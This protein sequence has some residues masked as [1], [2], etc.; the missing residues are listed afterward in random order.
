MPAASALAPRR[1][2]PGRRP[3]AVRR[4]VAG[5][6][7]GRSDLPGRP[8]RLRQVDPAQGAR[9]ADRARCR[10]ALPPA[11]HQ[12]RLPAAGARA[13]AGGQ[14]ARGDRSAGLPPGEPSIEQGRHRAL[15]AARAPR[16]SIPRRRVATLSGG[17]ARR[18]ALARALVG[19]PDVLLLDEPTNHLDLPTIERLEQ[20]L[21]GVS[22]RPRPGQPRPRL[23]RRAQPHDLVA[24]SR[25]ACGSWSRA[26]RPSTP[27]RRRCSPRRRRRCAG[28]RSASRR[29]PT[30]RTTASPRAASATRAGCA[31]CR[32]CARSARG[33]R[34]RS[35]R[36]S[37]S[38][39]PTRR[40]AGW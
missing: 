36:P 16:R 20:D 32:R 33:E 11:A 40:A 9:R 4:A 3:D 1:H 37:S 25:R 34:R 6:R 5:D 13:R 19:E 29:R 2:G 15:S 35:A 12:R 8:Q 18:V 22:R 24:R 39:R 26:S 14:R 38:R 23:P 10:R 7:Q 30:G 21:A 17:E 27:G 28:W 31:A